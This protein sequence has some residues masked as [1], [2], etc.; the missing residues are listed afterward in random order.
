MGK[1]ENEMRKQ[2]KI[3]K[4][5]N[6]PNTYTCEKCGESFRTKYNFNMHKKYS[7]CYK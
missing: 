5:I 1:Q 2:L 6:L 4:R 7:K 3:G